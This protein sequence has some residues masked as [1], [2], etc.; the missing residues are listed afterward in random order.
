M[1]CYHLNLILI[2]L[3]FEIQDKLIEIQIILQYEF[4]A[5]TTTTPSSFDSNSIYFD[6]V[7]CL[8]NDKNTSQSKFNG[9][10]KI[11]KCDHFACQVL[12]RR[13]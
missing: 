13:L 6:Q 8:K 7:T 2:E 3:I 4:L 11:H 5:P 10:A 1:V 12:L 9:N